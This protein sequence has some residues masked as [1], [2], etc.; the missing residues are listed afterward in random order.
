MASGKSIITRILLVFALIAAGNI[1]VAGVAYQYRAPDGSIVFTGEPL[2]LPFELIKK[3]ELDWGNVKSREITAQI[4]VLREPDKKAKRVNRPKFADIIEEKADKYKILPELVHAVIEAESAY[5]PNAVSHAGAVGLMQLMPKTAERFGVTDRTDP[6]QSIEGGT[7]YLRELLDYF[8][9]D[10]TLAIAGYNAGEG[11]VMKYGR[12]IPP[13]KETQNY[14]P[15][16]LR[17][18][19]RNLRKSQEASTVVSA[20][21]PAPG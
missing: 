11:A 19:R 2:E 16:V 10:L 20:G 12:T 4:P 3:M 13:Y 21:R 7:A 14:V 18:L 5:D 1:A 9:N 8:D 6:E 15:K 17:F